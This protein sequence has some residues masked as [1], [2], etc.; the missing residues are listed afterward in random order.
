[1]RK[2]MVL[3][4]VCLLLLAA[5]PALGAVSEDPEPF[6]PVAVDGPDT[7]GSADDPDPFSPE[8]T[9]DNSDPFSAVGDGPDPF[10]HV[11]MWWNCAIND[12]PDPFTPSVVCLGVISDDPEPVGRVVAP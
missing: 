4:V 11:S 12:N 7:T 5:S 9:N 6:S 1:M 3:P 8:V 10:G 2:T